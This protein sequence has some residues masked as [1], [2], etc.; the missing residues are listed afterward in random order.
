MLIAPTEPKELRKLGKT[1]ITPERHGV[2]I[3]FPS[4]GG[5]AGIQ[6]KTLNDLVAS[7]HDGRLQR[8]VVQMQNL[9]IKILI[10]EGAVHWTLDGFLYGVSHGWSK[11]QYLGLLWSLQ[12]KQV[13]ITH[14]T[15]LAE[16][17]EVVPL[18]IRWAAKSRHTSLSTRP[19]AVKW[20]ES[21][22]REWAIHLLQGFD[23][24]GPELAGR[25]FDT[26]GCIPLQWTVGPEELQRIP[27]VG[28][29]TV[30]RLLNGVGTS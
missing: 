1:S 5:L 11:A 14:T 27:G 2:D 29:T 6:R 19:G 8:E 25:I 20:G 4:A 9:A 17:I 7:V 12:G 15:S 21:S 13:W 16:T 18:V 10:V 30:A 26:F 23:G 22:Q 3:L 28:K 24:I